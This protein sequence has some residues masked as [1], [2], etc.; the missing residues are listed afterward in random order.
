MKNRNWLNVAE[1]FLL[2]GSGVGTL[3][4]VLSQQL[5]FT[6]APVS[7]LFLLNLVNRQRL[8]ESVQEKATASVA[9]LDR[10]VS[11]EFVSL[12]KQ[13]QALPSFLDLASL[14]KSV[15]HSH[16]E[17]IGQVTQGVELL[18]RE[19]EKPEW[20]GLNQNVRQL[21]EQYVG[22]ADSVASITQQ[23]NRL[24]D[25]TKVDGLERTIDQLR[26]EL[27][28]LRVS[29][30]SVS[31]EQK[32]HNFRG[33]QE[34]M[35]QINRRLNQ[36]PQPFD[37]SSLKQDIDSLIKAMGDAASRREV[38]R[39]VSQV[40]QL[41][42]QNS[43]I[44]QSVAPIK[45]ATTILKQQ[46]DTIASQVQAHPDQASTASADAAVLQELKSTVAALEQGLGQL[47][48]PN[49]GP[50]GP[51]A[52]QLGALQ[53]QIQGVQ[54]MTQTLDRQQKDLRDWV[55]R[56]PQIL[57]STALQTQVKALAKRVEWAESMGLEVQ[58]QVEA[59]VSA[60]LAGV[61]QQLE[62][63]RPVPQ[64]E[65]VFDV[66]GRRQQSA[67]GCAS[68]AILEQAVAQAEGRLVIVYPYPTPETLNTGLIQQ[69]R[70]LLDRQ[71]CLDIGWGH[72]GD[73][74]NGYQP[75]SLDRRR[76]VNAT[77]KGFLYDILNQLTQL[78]REY[79]DRFRFKVLGTDENFLVCDRSFAV[80]GTQSLPTASAVFP[81]AAMGLRTTHPEV[82]Q[83]LVDRFDD[84][85]LDADDV[86]AYFKR[87]ITRYDLGDRPGA[88]AD[89]TAVLQINPTDDVALNNRGLAHYDLGD[90]AAALADLDRAVQQNPNNFVAYCNRGVIRAEL[91][92]RL[93]AIEDYTCALQVNPDYATAYFHRG[94]ARTRMRN[95]IGAVQ[96]YT[97]VI[98]LNSEDGMAYFYRG[99]ACIKLGQRPAAIE[100]LQKATQLF[101]A[102]GDTTN[103]Q[104]ALRTLGKLQTTVAIAGSSQPLVPQGI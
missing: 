33:L 10:K 59:A 30:N 72:L 14:R 90:R 103:H 49:G 88:I 21:R 9:Q 80:L 67:G 75:R 27:A 65:L 60:R 23:I 2:A 91:G 92:D 97:E 19:L 26:T 32:Q 52:N 46:L 36:L 82:I 50:S 77:E 86:T 37:A 74:S 83:D 76:A 4:T 53:Q 89:Y 101:A 55:S 38:A 100:D 62:S 35:H 18:K 63:N 15:N 39:L 70:A 73:I 56:L 69:F 16:Q 17:A 71:G 57:D 20:R 5:L 87:A 95:K 24:S 98:R 34:Q 54:Q 25:S 79:P 61:M 102:Q 7:L 44:E 68:R 40:E 58:A 45:L 12:Q 81:Q 78:K 84:P 66:Q 93:G 42:Q 1:Y 99:L 85:V 8:D 29:L 13:V 51:V 96:D 41:S 31:D 64:Y 48:L 22:L 28:Q 3:A 11:G 94:L 47:A 43:T 104:Q 6:A